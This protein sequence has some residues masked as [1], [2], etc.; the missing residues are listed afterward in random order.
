MQ[1]VQAEEHGSQ[2]NIRTLQKYMVMG[3]HLGY[4]PL[5]DMKLSMHIL[6]IPSIGNPPDKFLE[7][8]R[9]GLGI[10]KLVQID[11]D[12]SILLIHR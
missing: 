6:K 10:G 2:D 3:T 4:I 8:G 9:L 5:T 12:I 11:S 1:I 7:L